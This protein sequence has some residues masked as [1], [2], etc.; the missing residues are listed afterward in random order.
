[1]E[2]PSLFFKN[3]IRVLALA[4]VLFIGMGVSGF[5]KAQ[6]T[7]PKTAG[8]TRYVAVNGSD[9]GNCASPSSPCRTIQ[10]A[11]NQASSGD[12]ILVASGTYTYEPNSDKCSF[13]VTRAVVCLVDKSLT[14]KGGYTPSNW[15]HQDPLS[16]LTIIDGKNTYRGVAVIAYNSTSSLSMEGFTIQN[17]KAQGIPGSDGWRASGRGGGLWSQGG[18]IHLRQMVFKNN[19]ALAA[20]TN[21]LGGDATGGAV[22]IESVRNGLTSTLEDVLF[23]SNQALGSNGSQ[24]GGLA[25][26][27]ALFVYRSKIEGENLV[28]QGNIA[29]AGDAS[30]YGEWNQLR[31]DALGGA[32]SLQDGSQAI[33]RNLEAY[34]NEALGGNAQGV[35]GGGFG[36]A[37]HVEDSSFLATSAKLSRNIAKGGKG[38]VGG[39]AMGGGLMT[40]D[41]HLGLDRA[42]VTLNQ[43]I[44][45]ETV[46]GGTPTGAGGGGLYLTAFTRPNAFTLSLSNVIVADNILDIEGQ[47]IKVGGSGAGVVVQAV[48]AN[49]DH[50]TIANNQ[51]KDDA[52]FGQAIMIVGLRPNDNTGA[53]LNLRNSIVADHIHPFTKLTSAVTVIQG[54]KLNMQR[55]LFANNT[56]DINT[57]SQPV[58]AGMI[59]GLDTVIKTSS[60]GFV[61]SGAPNYDYHL[62]PSSIAVDRA[63]GELLNADF[64]GDHRP[65]NG[66][67][68]IGAD[69]YVPL[70]LRVVPDLLVGITDKNIPVVF[71]ATVLATKPVNARWSARTSERWISFGMFP[72][73]SETSGEIGE[74]LVVYILPEQLSEGWHEGQIMLSSPEAEPTILVVRVLVA[75]EVQ[76]IYLPLVIKSP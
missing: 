14:I 29:K 52:R 51:V 22:M 76:R 54:S 48:T 31:A 59:T 47:G 18:S 71:T 5:S 12:T 56:N 3:Q 64:E 21:S 53:T 62:L 1:M 2:Y 68:D 16:N 65:Y 40:D 69:E 72:A 58:P 34:E 60:A 46:G 17:G 37:V 35:G 50:V 25:L 13:L 10:Y 39:Y 9:N 23:Q 36:G 45:G 27:G 4:S 43:S 42:V 75:D 20:S 32:I 74:K 24:R 57:N 6:E 38:N 8:V 66:V 28:F 44:A 11:V 73:N 30:G 63:M 70:R 41:S 61:S 55:V 15:Q 19:I 49:L 7:Q 33:F 26:G 67:S